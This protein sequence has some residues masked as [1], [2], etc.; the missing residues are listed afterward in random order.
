[1]TGAP[2]IDDVRS[3]SYVTYETA[4]VLIAHGAGAK[5]VVVVLSCCVSA[6]VFAARPSPRPAA[7]GAQA[8][9]APLRRVVARNGASPHLV[10]GLFDDA[11][12]NAGAL[13]REPTNALQALLFCSV[14]AIRTRGPEIVCVA[15][16][17]R[18]LVRGAGAQDRRG[19]RGA[20]LGNI[21]RVVPVEVNG[22]AESGTGR[23]AGEGKALETKK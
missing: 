18:A 23:I 17:A 14:E 6:G 9:R 5:V 19:C 1:M 20:L 2:R 11:R 21:Q 10:I 4:I 3:D 13:P 8:L 22:R 7:A 16:G 12:I 15:R